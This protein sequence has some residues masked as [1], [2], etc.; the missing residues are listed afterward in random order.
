MIKVLFICHGNICRSPMAEYILKDM[1]TARGLE[2]EY[3]VDSAATSR[4]E[5]GNP[6]Y[7]PAKAELRRHGIACE[8]HRARQVRPEDYGEYDLI[9]GMEDRH[10]RLLRERFFN[11]D[12]EGKVHLCM[13]LAGE[14]GVQ[15]EDPWYT[16]DF[17]GV[18]DQLYRACKGILES[19]FSGTC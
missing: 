16:G 6:V 5:I 2:A 3:R 8:G 10:V 1:V 13:E 4:E 7:P 15:V 17:A 18:Y 12:P 19:G 9:I 14:P 11:G